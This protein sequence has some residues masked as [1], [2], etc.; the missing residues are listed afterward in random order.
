MSGTTSSGREEDT[1]LSGLLVDLARQVRESPLTA[2]ALAACIAIFVRIQA[3]SGDPEQW[4]LARFGAPT[5]LAVWE[6]ALWALFTGCFVHVE[7]MHLLFNVSCLWF[8]GRALER[9]IGWL[10]YAGLI[11]GAGSVSSAAELAVTG[12]P[13]IGVSG[14]AYALFGFMW[15]ARARVPGFLEVLDRRTITW[16]LLWMI[17]CYVATLAGVWNVANVAHLSGLLFGA[18][19]GAVAT[20][21]ARR[22]VALAGTL[23]LTV[24]SM[25]FALWRPWDASWSMWRAI[26]AHERGELDAAEQWYR[27]SLAQ[28]QEPAWVWRN[29]GHLALA[30]DDKP[31]YLA[32]YAEL[33]GDDSEEARAL[34]GF[35]ARR[36]EV[37]MAHAAEFDLLERKLLEAR[38]AGLDWN[39]QR[40]EDLHRRLVAEYPDDFRA[41][42]GLAD[43]LVFVKDRASKSELREALELAR[44]AAELTG[45]E[46]VDVLDTL[47]EACFRNGDPHAALRTADE[48]QALLR[49]RE[50]NAAPEYLERYEK[51]REAAGR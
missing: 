1:R 35:A 25:S 32:A 49:D 22:R 39:W 7:L 40:A 8:L 3:S 33:K 9:E 6:G 34:A 27:R 46:D 24:S 50:T 12:Q 5:P 20:R 37:R 38:L 13:C 31:G 21:P 11:L 19:V 26:T 29:L 23:L 36:Q 43:F 2:L 51:Y 41:S 18:G 44:R 16:F 17:G 48:W 15:S 47:A 42:I 10:G 45:R 4:D 30:R 14:I 28:G